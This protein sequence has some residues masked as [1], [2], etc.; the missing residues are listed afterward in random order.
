MRL[1]CTRTG[2]LLGELAAPSGD[3]TCVQAVGSETS[4]TQMRA[5]PQPAA[6]AAP[7][8][9]SRHGDN[10][11]QPIRTLRDWLDH[12][13]LRE[14]LLVLKPGV[15]LRFELAAIAKRLDGA[16]CDVVPASR[17]A[18]RSRS[19]PASSPTAAGWPRRWA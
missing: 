4:V 2:S 7:G 17:R 5:V 10:A 9:V 16:T 19:S 12:L 14:R 8:A 6:Q 3:D 11:P 13:A 15:G 18:S 1:P